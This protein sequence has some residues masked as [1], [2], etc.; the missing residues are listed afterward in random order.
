MDKKMKEKGT[1]DKETGTDK[2]KL[3]KGKGKSCEKVVFSRETET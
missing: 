1:G 3:L 2:M